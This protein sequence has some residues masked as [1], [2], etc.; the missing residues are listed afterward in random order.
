MLPVLA[1]TLRLYGMSFSPYSEKARWALDHHGITYEW[2]E[3]VPM[4]GERK[5]RKAAGA[6][7]GKVSVPLA[8][9]GNAVLRDSLAIARHAERLG[10]GAALFTNATAVE[11]WAARSDEALGA[12]R[13]LLLART[14]VDRQALRDSLPGWVPGLLRGLATPLAARA[15]R[16]IARKYGAEGVA[17]EVSTAKLRAVLAAMRKALRSR[18]T[19][20]DGFS[21]ADIAMAVV[22]QMIC[23]VAE[24]YIAL[25]PAR[26]RAW[27][28]P[29]LAGEY[30]D[31]VAWRDA[32]YAKR[33][34]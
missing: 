14:L 8:I 21:Y 5:L 4:V 34:S 2:H 6:V 11:T 23:P 28:E 1:M 12:A 30:A 20:L 9:D 32:V 18:D 7:A 27:T 3:H 15:T 33:R 25:G 31:L 19:I 24:Q 13:C 17:P 29:T 22:I 10:R 16:F 26:R